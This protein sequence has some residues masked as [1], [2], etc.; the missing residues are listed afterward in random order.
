MKCGWDEVATT[1]LPT[2]YE[3]HL[4]NL[5]T[6][7]DAAL[8][9]SQAVVTFPVNMTQNEMHQIQ[10]AAVNPLNQS[11]SEVV[12]F[13]LA[14]I[15]VPFTPV[16]K[17]INISDTSL[18]IYMHWRNQTSENQR[19]CEVE[20]RTLKQPSWISV[21]EEV[22][23]NN[24]ISLE[25]IR[26][27]DSIRIRCREDFGKSYW[28]NWSAPHL[29]PPSAPEEIPNV[30]RL[31][32]SSLPDGVRE[33]TFLFASDLDDLRRINISGYEVYH[34]NHGVRTV[35]KRC[36][37]PVAQ[38]VALIPSGVQTVLVAAYNP[39]GFSPALHLPLQEE[40]G[41]GPQ[42]VT[43]K[44]MTVQWQHPHT[45]PEP[46]RWYALQWASD[47][48][49]GK[50]TNISTQKTEKERTTYT[51]TDNVAPG[52]RVTISLYAVYSTRVSRP[53]TV[54]GFS[55]E[56]KPTTGPSSIKI[57]KPLLRAR[58]IEWDEI[59]VCDR[60]GFLTV[61]TVY[62]KQYLNE[63]NFVYKVPAST[64][65][66]LFDR[67]N[68]DDQYSVCISASTV[69]GEGPAVHCTNFYQDNDFNSY[70]GLLVGTAFGVIA[71]S[72]IILILSRIWK[73]VKIGLLLLLPK[74]LHEEYPH[75]GRSPAVKSLQENI[76]S[77][78]PPPVVLLDDPEIAE[79]E[80]I[81]K[82][83]TSL[84]IP[85]TNPAQE[86][87]NMME[88]PLIPA[89]D[90]EVPSGYR[91]QIANVT[92]HQHNSYFSPAQ[93]L[94][95]QRSILGSESPVV[96][97]NDPFLLNVTSDMFKE[98]NLMVTTDVDLDEEPL[99]PPTNPML[100]NLWENQT[101]IDRLILS[102]SPGDHVISTPGL[103]EEFDDTKSYFS[104][105]FT[106]GL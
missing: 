35:L 90:I 10:I 15:V 28:S 43:V 73:R 87:T 86:S 79:I 91:P 39:F 69:A 99:R 9:T 46:L 59:P 66:L 84:L 77:P 13:L 100:Q 97:T 82:E 5:W 24:I 74:C 71:L 7:A 103:H 54:Y 56:L 72:A 3:V 62:I 64:R 58:I 67:F 17:K 12:R 94:D 60:R 31:L 105:L 53:T 34:Y 23:T 65:H 92:S 95:L 101:F 6:G 52:Q 1:R 36:P 33:V 32:G 8:S 47:S 20:Y 26:H 104:Q 37:S 44:S 14:D 83:E 40:D 106:G 22:N 30:W 41:S 45:P 89:T 11:E 21:G 38:C 80:E 57:V 93:L 98:M 55:Q 27:A 50:H 42:N 76:E 63:S 2:R 18:R 75:V 25:K 4:K 88:S 85:S 16:I 81:P 70:M 49:D 48:C 51:I 68:P 96:P 19:Y 61:Y 102:E 78:E 29:V